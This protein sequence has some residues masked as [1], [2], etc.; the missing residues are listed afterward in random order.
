MAGWHTLRPPPY[1]NTTF[2][3]ETGVHYQIH[4]C[5]PQLPVGRK[6]TKKAHA[7]VYRLASSSESPS[8]STLGVFV[9][10]FGRLFVN[11]PDI[12]EKTGPRVSKWTGYEVF[13]DLAAS[14][15]CFQQEL[16]SQSPIRVVSS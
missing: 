16:T 13:L 12:N 5:Y 7:Y 15:D 8:F 2:E 9:F 14:L 1:R 6:A 11:K 4:P 10:P 3:D